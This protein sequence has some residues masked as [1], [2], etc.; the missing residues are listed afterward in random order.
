MIVYVFGV[1]NGEYRQLFHVGGED[2]VMATHRAMTNGA[3]SSGADT[4][5]LFLLKYPNDAEELR[6]HAGDS[7]DAWV[8][9][10]ERTVR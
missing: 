10:I 8:E 6:R 3:K 1:N 4:S 7:Y 9:I 5:A 2:E